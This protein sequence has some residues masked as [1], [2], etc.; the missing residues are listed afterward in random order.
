MPSATVTSKGQ[1][2][3]PKEVREALGVGA[4]DRVEFV[5][6]GKGVFEVTARSRDVRELKGTLGRRRRPV[7]IEDMRKAVARRAGR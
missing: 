2:T 4:G 6:T 3:L 7:N 5:E 1:I